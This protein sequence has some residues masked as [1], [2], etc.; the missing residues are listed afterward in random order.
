MASDPNNFPIRDWSKY[1]VRMEN[2][3]DGLAIVIARPRGV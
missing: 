2:S 3:R 1:S